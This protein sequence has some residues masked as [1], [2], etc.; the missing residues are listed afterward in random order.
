MIMSYNPRKTGFE[1]LKYQEY[2]PSN[3]IL[4]SLLI[5]LGENTQHTPFIGCHPNFYIEHTK[6]DDIN[7]LCSVDIIFS[8]TINKQF[9]IL[10][11]WLFNWTWSMGSTHGNLS[12]NNII[13]QN[14][15]FIIIDWIDT[16]AYLSTYRYILYYNIL[17]DIHNITRAYT[18][19]LNQTNVMINNIYSSL[20]ELLFNSTLKSEHY[21]NS[22]ITS[23]TNNYL[24]EYFIK[25]SLEFNSVNN[26]IHDL[27]KLTNNSN[28]F[29]L[30]V[31]S[32]IPSYFLK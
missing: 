2:A 22:S 7:R 9:Y 20:D 11:D 17:L 30:L 6:I 10:L 21:I 25:K 5:S 4:I 8:D 23:D 27:L 26:I 24:Y 13:Y 14:T 15:R 31:C 3:Y 19:R 1:F 28:N 29:N 12:D 16:M 18:Q 32:L